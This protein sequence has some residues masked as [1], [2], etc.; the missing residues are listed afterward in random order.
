MKRKC[1]CNEKNPISVL[2]GVVFFL[3]AF[4]VLMSG[5]QAK[6]ITID[7]SFDDW[8]GTPS[9]FEGNLGSFPYPGTTYYFNLGTDSWQTGAPGYATCMYNENRALE[10]SSLWMAN[11]N[12]NLFF[13]LLRGSDF[14]EYFWGSGGETERAYF[15]NSPASSTNSNPCANRIVTFPDNLHGEMVFEFDRNRGGRPEYF[16]EFYFSQSQGAYV[17]G[18][19][20]VLDG[21]H[22]SVSVRILKDGGDGVFSENGDDTQVSDFG[23]DEFAI[24]K[25]VSGGSGGIF[26]ETRVD[27]A[28]FL[29]GTK[30]ERG[31]LF[32]I[33]YA[34]SGEGATV[35]PTGTYSINEKKTIKLSASFS[36]ETTKSYISISGSTKPRAHV[37]LLLDGVVQSSVKMKNNGKFSKKLML[38]VGTHTVKLLASSDDGTSNISRSVI[39][40]VRWAVDRPLELEIIRCKNETK[41]SVLAISGVAYGVDKVKISINGADWGYTVVKKIKGGYAAR[42]RLQNGENTIAVTATDGTNTVT[43]TKIVSKI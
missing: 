34:N 16:L 27:L 6:T 20:G 2:F 17:T 14:A 3:L 28:K 15:S 43:Q 26:Q 32:D 10:A 1:R 22:S 9:V 29:D 8:Q 30:I 38:A 25:G 37:D 41:K 23:A 13:K 35:S 24:S 7:G 4:F 39:R 5:A 36:R 12:N 40:K 11:D 21:N 42:I 31:N 19:S 33:Q 18:D